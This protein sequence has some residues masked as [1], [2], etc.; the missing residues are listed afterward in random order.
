MYF[1]YLSEFPKFPPENHRASPAHPSP[2]TSA[3]PAKCSAHLSPPSTVSV[4]SP[5]TPSAGKSSPPFA[6]HSSPP[7]AANSCPP[8]AQLSALIQAPEHPPVAALAPE[9]P[10]VSALAPERPPERPPVPAPRKSPPEGPP[11]PSLPERPQ[12]PAPP[13]RQ[14]D[15]VSGPGRAL[16]SSTFPKDFFWGS[17]RAPV[18]EAGAGLGPRPW[19]R[20]RHGLLSSPIHHGTPSHLIR[21]ELPDP[22]PGGVPRIPILHQPPGHPPPPDM[23][24]RGT[25]LPGVGGNV[26]ESRS[27]VTTL[28]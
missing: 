22:S 21:H 15:P 18:I 8:A 4:L 14:P 20:S 24:R 16:G 17:S 28:T 3:Y 19:R 23:L 12:V 25:R 7:A 1:T 2:G 27:P 6:A 5:E 13:E 11:V 10:P 9:H 26:R